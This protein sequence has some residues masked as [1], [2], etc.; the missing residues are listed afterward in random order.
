MSQQSRFLM[1]APQFYEVAY[2]INPW[3]SVQKKVTQTLA[4]KQWQRY[5]ELLTGELGAQVDLIEPVKGLPDMVFTANAGLISNRFFVRSNFRF[6]ERRGEEAYF[7][8]YFKTQGY[9]VKTIQP[10]FC[11]EGEGDALYMNSELYTGFHFRSDLEAHDVLSG[12]VR[13]TY[14]ALE[15]CDDRFYHLDTCFSPLNDRTALIFFEA[16]APY[17][18]LTLWENVPDPISVPEEEALQFACNAVVIGQKIV[19]PQNCP[20]TTQELEKRG[21]D[22]YALDFSEF[23]KAGGAAKCLVLSLN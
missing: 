15:L 6:K 5:Y 14:F 4:Q 11:F 21:F 17:A 8:K 19:I 13:S 23:I 18:Q 1:C 7:E 16:F 12:Y 22:V 3:M 20:K 2:E 9:K 10:P